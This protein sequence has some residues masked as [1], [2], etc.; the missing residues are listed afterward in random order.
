MSLTANVKLLRPRQ[1][2]KNIFVFAL[3]WSIGASL[4]GENRAKFDLYMKKLC[5]EAVPDGLIYDHVFSPETKRWEKWTDR[6]PAY[7]EPSPFA[8]YKIIV[9]TK[10]S[11]LYMHLLEQQAPRRP[12]LFVGESGTSKTVCVSAYLAQLD[13]ETNSTLTMGF[14][15]RTTSTPGRP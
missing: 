5:M 2:V 13:S 8:F 12:I 4:L 1:W 3:T 6:V 10:D 9:P 7:E 14:S 11:V 15:S